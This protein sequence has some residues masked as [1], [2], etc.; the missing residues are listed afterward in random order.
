MAR[1]FGPS[2][3]FA[4]R[5]EG[6]DVERGAADERT[7]DVRLRHQ[8][9]RVVGLDRAAVEHRTV[10]QRLHERMRLL[11]H[12]RR[13]GASRADR[14]HGLVRQDE[15]LVR[16]AR[17]ADRVDLDA[18]HRLHVA[19]VALLLRLAD[20][21]DDAEP[22]IERSL[23]APRNSRIRLAEVL[24]PLGV[25]DQRAGDAEAEQHRRRD[26]ACVRALVLPVDV[27]RIRREP[28]LDAMR[29]GD[30]GRAHDGL[31]AGDACKALGKRHGIR[32]REHL[33]VAGDDHDA[34]ST[35]DGI[36][37]T[38]GSS[39]PSSSSRLA[40]PPVETHVIRAASP[41]SLSA[42]T[43]SAPPTTENDASFAATASAT[44]FVPSAN[45]GHSKTPMGPFQK[46]VRASERKPAN[47]SRVSGP[48]S[49]PSQPSG[50]SS[51]PYTPDSA[52]SLNSAAPTTSLG[53]S[54]AKSSGFSTRT[55][56]AILP[57]MST[58]S[59]P[60]PRFC[61]TPSLS[62]TFA[63]PE[64]ITNG[65]STSPSSLPRWRSSS[66]SSRPA[67]AGSTC[68]TPSVE[69]CARWAEPNASFT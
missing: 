40:P 10:E 31:D 66:S 15:P 14:P 43:E 52:S 22:G 45:R 32:S 8:L 50:R 3:R 9:V 27:L 24:A 61:R 62:S 67:Y 68:A 6:L 23:G 60:P 65:R 59:A 47:R 44:A 48:M 49:R 12:L 25:A 11:R 56:S 5:R 2:C 69:A 21:R 20:A 54:T 36:A 13:R 19:C 64:T 63:P 37:A 46:I 28:G 53:S 35:P 57:P 7:V 30:P 17:V 26:L 39:L 1:A 41:S 29:E 42:R 33:P 58:G 16:T 51:T 55:C 38:P 4:Y 18:Q 34:T